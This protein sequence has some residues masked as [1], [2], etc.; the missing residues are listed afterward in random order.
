MEK[1]LYKVAVDLPSKYARLIDLSG[2][3]LVRY[4]SLSSG[5][6]PKQKRR[7]SRCYFDRKPIKDRIQ[8]SHKTEAVDNSYQ[9]IYTSIFNFLSN[10]AI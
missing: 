5:W 3:I 4:Y 2:K 7:K 10:P 1:E 6:Q 8:Q 9:G